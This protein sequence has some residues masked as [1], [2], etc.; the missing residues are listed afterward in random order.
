MFNTAFT[1]RSFNLEISYSFE[2]YEPMKIPV[3]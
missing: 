2:G 1:P 3:S